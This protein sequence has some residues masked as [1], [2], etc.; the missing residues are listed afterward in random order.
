MAIVHY[1]ALVNTIKGKLGDKI[2]QKYKGTDYIRTAPASV[3]QPNTARQL[4]IKRNLGILSKAF[5]GITDQCKQ[6]WDMYASM[7]NMHCFGQQAYI[8]LNAN[9]L[10]ASHDELLCHD[11]PPHTPATPKHAQGFCVQNLSETRVKLSWTKPN[12]DQTYVTAHFRL[13]RR[14]CH[15]HPCYALCP[16]V[17][18]RP[19]WRFV[20]TERAD[21]LKMQHVHDWPNDTRLFYRLN[22]IDKSGR[23]SPFSHAIA[24]TFLFD[25]HI[26]IT[27]YGNNRLKKHLKSDLSYVAKFGT[28]GS[29]NDQFNGPLGIAGDHTYIYILEKNNHRLKKHLKSDLSYVAKIG[30]LGSGND[31]FNEPTGITVDDTHIYIGDRY[32]DRIVKRLK[33]D[34]SFVAKIGSR[35]SGNDQFYSVAG[36]AADSTYLYLCDRSNYRIQKRLKSDLSFVAKFGTQGAGDDQ[37]NEPMHIAVDDTYLYISDMSNHRIKKHLKSDLSFVAKIGSQGS[38]DNQ[39]N[40]PLGITVDDTYIY[41]TDYLNHR[42]KK[43][44]KSDLS[45][46][47]KFGTDGAGNDQFNYPYANCTQFSF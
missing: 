39:F 28:T 24:I 12:D 46:V 44:L 36:T 14:F 16:T 32:N 6:L 26:Y 5:D 25:P 3:A 19:A 31:Q 41:I 43:H 34:L 22:S 33:S 10:N 35:G 11:G 27:D 38:A 9:I 42:I 17:G 37:F 30:S 4:Q 21:Q 8:K 20:K 18:Y 40:Y 45:F 47:A 23:K 1:S 13:H 7:A 2:Y 29:G 15:Q